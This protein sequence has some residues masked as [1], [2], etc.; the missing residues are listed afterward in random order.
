MQNLRTAQ[1]RRQCLK[2]RNMRSIGNWQLFTRVKNV[3]VRHLFSIVFIKNI[4]PTIRN[5]ICLYV[6]WLRYEKLTIFDYGYWQTL[7]VNR[8]ISG[9]SGGDIKSADFVTVVIFEKKNSVIFPRA[10]IICHVTGKCLKWLCI[11]FYIMYV[12][13]HFSG[14]AEIPYIFVSICK[15]IEQT[16]KI[17]LPMS[18]IYPLDRYYILKFTSEY[19]EVYFVL[20]LFL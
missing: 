15:E 9:Y 16:I 5:E 18:L 6:I 12:K 3:F 8:C 10:R 2:F 11:A 4:H 17:H 1:R 14:L 13:S 19:F 7:D 20:V